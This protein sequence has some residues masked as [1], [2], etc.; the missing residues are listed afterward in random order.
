MNPKGEKEYII[1]ADESLRDGKYFSNFYGGVLVG[2][3]QHDKL[4]ARLNKLKVKLGFHGEVKWSKVTDQYLDR[5]LK[6][7]DGFFKEVK[8]GR[9]KVRIMFTKNSNVPPRAV[10][11]DME[12]Y[13]K[14]YYQFI[15]HAFGLQYAATRPRGTRVRLLFDQWPRTGAS[16]AAFRQFLTKLTHSPEFREARLRVE[17]QDI[18]EVRSHDHVLLQCLDVVL[19]AMAFRLNDMHKEMPPGRKRRG[20]RTIAKEN[21][22]KAINDHIQSNR[23]GFNIGISTGKTDGMESLWKD[24]YR[25]WC[26]VPKNAT[27][28]DGKTKGAERKRKGPSAPT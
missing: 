4:S 28:D 22:Y 13:F 8:A 10:A 24:P 23:K 25:H 16:S 20:R 5:Y 6:L 14:L 3:S 15:K 26:F 17:A 12:G 2:A 7:V 18:A 1:L 21:L 27:Y 19:G 9:V 11:S